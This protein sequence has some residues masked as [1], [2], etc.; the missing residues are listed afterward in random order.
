MLTITNIN[1]A[2]IM[3]NIAARALTLTE[4]GYTYRP[5]SISGL[6]WVKK[7]NGREYMVDITDETPY[8]SCEGFKQ[9]GECSHRLWVKEDQAWE[10]GVMARYQC[11]RARSMPID[12]LF[13]PPPPPMACDTLARCVSCGDRYSA[14][15]FKTSPWPSAGPSPT[16]EHA[17]SERAGR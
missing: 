8:C 4:K 12:F 11:E 1:E 5:G 6:F 3:A 7:P 16:T 10:T 13:Y 9:N 2:R 15:G 17:R 14:P